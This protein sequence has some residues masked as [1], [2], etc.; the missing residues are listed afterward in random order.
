MANVIISGSA[1]TLKSALK[2]ASLAKVSN[3]KPD[4]L[5]V[6]DDKNNEKFRIAFDKK[7]TGNMSPKGIS[8]DKKDRAGYA[9]ITV[10]HPCNLEER[11]NAELNEMFA[12]IVLPLA[13]L[14]RDIVAKMPDLEAE[15]N[16]VAGMI[17]VM[18]APVVA[19]DTTEEEA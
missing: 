5:V 7:L 19:E 2:A 12:P 11:T 3:L 8:F 18:A 17:T 10:L 13:A 15:L 1:V 9:M 4:W 6:K 16:A 14:E